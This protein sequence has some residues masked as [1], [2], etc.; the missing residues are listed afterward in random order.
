MRREGWRHDH[1]LEVQ[2]LGGLPEGVRL[3][4]DAD[5][6]L[7]LTCKL[8]GNRSGAGVSSLEGIERHTSSL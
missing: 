5:V 7:H 1:D 2:P 3:H 6:L 8:L 4:G